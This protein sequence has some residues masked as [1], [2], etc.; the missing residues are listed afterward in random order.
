M[1]HV[2]SAKFAPVALTALILGGCSSLDSFLPNATPTG[3]PTPV[4]GTYDKHGR[5]EDFSR[6]AQSPA[7]KLVVL[8]PSS[9]DIVCPIVEIR[10]GG[11][12]LRNGGPSNESVRTQFQVDNTARECD[13]GA[14]PSQITVKIGIQ[15][16]LLIGPAGSPGTYGAD[17]RVAI[18]HDA[19]QKIVVA[20]TYH[21]SATSNA[22]GEGPFEIVTELLPLNVDGY[23]VANQYSIFVGFGA[24]DITVPKK[25]TR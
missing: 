18:R 22:G 16:K 15:G 11:A 24:G 2:L 9:A 6:P 17:L 21:V 5:W 3:E 13:P 19:D 25:R 1:G 12:A 10:E 4:L 20:K 14:S 7:E 23:D 8:P